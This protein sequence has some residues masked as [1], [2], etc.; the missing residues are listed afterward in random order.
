[1]D[2]VLRDSV[3]VAVDEAALA[4]RRL[5]IAYRDAAGLIEED[6]DLSGLFR[7]L[8]SEH[9]AMAESLGELVDRL[10]ALPSE[11]DPDRESL[12]KLIRHARAAVSSDDRLALIREAERHEDDLGAQ[13]A[14]ALGEKIPA[15]HRLP[16][17]NSARRVREAQRRLADARARIMAGRS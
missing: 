4:A 6:G 8:A 16:L 13:L 5:T 2:S 12:L 10:G 17:E 7:A 9:D 15:E 14:A 11:H 1:M 3:Q